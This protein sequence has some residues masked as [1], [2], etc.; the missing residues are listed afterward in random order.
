[1]SLITL[2]KY[3]DAQLYYR[4]RTVSTGLVSVKG[5]YISLPLCARTE[6]LAVVYSSVPLM[7]ISSI[8]LIFTTSGL[9]Y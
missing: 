5:F 1:M 3:Q 8:K 7:R 4:K 2:W 6:C 9:S